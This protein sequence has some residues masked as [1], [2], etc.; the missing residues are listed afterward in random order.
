MGL[1]KP[2]IGDVFGLSRIYDLQ[3]ENID[4]KSFASWPES[5]KYGYF[6]GGRN[7]VSAMCTISRLDFSNE[8]AN[9]PGKNLSGTLQASSN[10]SNNSYAYF[11]GGYINGA[12]ACTIARL[13]FSNETVSDPGKNLSKVRHSSSGVSNNS[14]G[15]FCGGDPWTSPPITNPTNLIQRLDFSNET[16]SDPGK[17]M[18]TSRNS[19]AELSNNSYGYFVGGYTPT[20]GCL[21]SRLDFSNE[22]TSD[23]GKNLNAAGDFIATVSNNSYGLGVEG[24]Y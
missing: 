19:A 10:V 18:P 5:A 13:D 16:I 4:N 14:Y 2:F 17:N 12:T 6:V 24:Y 3:V 8:T 22:T 21:I 9:L 15:Y 20:I 1:F 23:P 7:S 11:G